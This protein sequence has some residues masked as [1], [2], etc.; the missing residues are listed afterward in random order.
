MTPAPH[1][2]Y[3]F[4]LGKSGRSALQY[5]QNK[6]LPVRAWDDTA[7]T[8]G[9]LDPKTLQDPT[10]INW[11]SVKA[12]V[13]SPGIPH[14]GPKAH[15]ALLKAQAHGVPIIVDVEIF[16]ERALSHPNHKIIGITGT[17]GKSTTTSLLCH[18]LNYF[19]KKAIAAGNIGTPVLDLPETEE[20]TYYILELSSYQ[21]T[22]LKT[23]RLDL[24]VLI[25]ITPD[26]LAYHGTME[27]YVKA[28]ASIFDFLRAPRGVIV[29]DDAYTQAIHKKLPMFLSVS[30]DTEAGSISICN[31]IL[32]DCVHNTALTLPILQQLQGSHNAQNIGACYA[33]L[34]QLIPTDFNNAR[35]IEALQSFQS[36]PHRQEIVA[37][38]PHVTFV[39]D[40]KATNMDAA[41]K[42]LKTFKNIHWI[43]GGQSK[44]GETPIS[45]KHLFSHVRHVYLVGSSMTQFAKDL[46]GLIPYT[47]S[48]TVEKAT[49][50]AFQDAQKGD[51]IL[52]APACASFDQ[53]KNFEERGSIFRNLAQELGRA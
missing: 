32:K 13:L 46:E 18:M 37:Q 24:A 30:T 52:L 7:D 34:Q 26:H 51:V 43:L 36:L 3:V 21:L 42:S 48:H 35:F 4:G 20:E 38:T 9:T 11:S 16:L 14:E 6:N 27:A 41:E 8:R 53:F 25:N 49:K 50:E 17:N 15:A 22:L 2:W 28:K 31:H 5:L 10:T 29:I 1:F 40:S 12:I 45:L 39:N 44:L 19:G 23:P 47:L 33:A